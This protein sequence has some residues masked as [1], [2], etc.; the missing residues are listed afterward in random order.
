MEIPVDAVYDYR[1]LLTR[2]YPLE[3]ALSIVSLKYFLDKKQRLLLYRCVHSK[4]YVSV[5]R[6]KIVRD[7]SGIEG[8]VIDFYNILLTNIEMFAKKEVFLCDD[9]LIRDLRGS[10]IHADE[11]PFL[12]SIFLKIAN[13]IKLIGFRKVIVVADKNISYSMEY[14]KQFTEIMKN[15]GIDCQGVLS[16]TTDKDIIAISTE[17]KDMVV[18]TTDIVIIRSVPRIYPLT[19]CLVLLYRDEYKVLDISR[20]LGEDCS[21]CMDKKCIDAINK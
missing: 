10:K 8:M 11:I 14:L 18:A 7:S 21:S 9:C 16:K 13:A 6:S 17:N 15:H 1:Y 19:N 2:G 20:I 5:A 3:H 12:S 4:H